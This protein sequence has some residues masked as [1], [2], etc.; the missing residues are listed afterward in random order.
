MSSLLGQNV[1]VDEMRKSVYM[2]ARRRH[3]AVQQKLAQHSDRLCHTLILKNIREREESENPDQPG[4]PSARGLLLMLRVQSI[5]VSV[6]V[7]VCVCV[8]KTH[9]QPLLILKH[10]I[11]TNPVHKFWFLTPATLPIFSDHPQQ[12]FMGIDTCL[13]I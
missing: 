3:F 2:Y 13:L 8:C 7:C 5:I 1:L 4:T 6:C 11:V 12:C 10:A 9:T